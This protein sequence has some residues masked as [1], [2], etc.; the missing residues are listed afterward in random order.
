[1]KALEI[2]QRMRAR[3]PITQ[4]MLQARWQVPAKCKDCDREEFKQVGGSEHTDTFCRHK[5]ACE[6]CG[7]SFF[8][9]Q[10]QCRN[11]SKMFPRHPV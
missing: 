1:M 6:Y 3:L 5:Y 4:G 2:V 10:N 11:V 9:A 7:L 8:V